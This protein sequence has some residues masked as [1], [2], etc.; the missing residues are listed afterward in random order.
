MPGTI[1][2]I[3]GDR[4]A[5]SALLMYKVAAMEHCGL[6]ARA[7]SDRR[8]PGERHTL[9]NLMAKQPRGRTV[10]VDLCAKTER[11]NGAGKIL[12]RGRKA[13][14]ADLEIVFRHV[15]IAPPPEMAGADP[16]EITCVTAMEVD[17]PKGEEMIR[18]HLLSTLPVETHEDASRVVRRY[19]LR[20]IVEEFHGML[21]SDGCDI[22]SLAVSAHG[23]VAIRTI[24][25]AE[26]ADRKSVV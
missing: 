10:A 20:W 6:I 2:I 7:R 12:S 9:F 1:Q 19:H 15:R 26:P 13:R 3:V 16:L 18:W 5:D 21:K 11:R 23:G 25:Q 4:G 8:L 24:Q 22:E 14:K 17:P